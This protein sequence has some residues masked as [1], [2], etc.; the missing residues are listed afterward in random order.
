M[1]CS[2]SWFY[3]DECGELSLDLCLAGLGSQTHVLEGHTTNN[4][5]DVLKKVPLSMWEGTS[6]WAMKCAVPM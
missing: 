1:I 6:P 4:C 2:N 3:T 5:S